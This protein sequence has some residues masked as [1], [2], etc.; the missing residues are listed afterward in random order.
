M[1]NSTTTE[2]NTMAGTFHTTKTAKIQFALPEFNDTAVIEH[3]AHVA[4]ELGRYDII[5]GGDLLKAIGMDIK[6]S[7]MM[8]SWGNTEVPMKSMDATPNVFTT[9]DS[10]PIH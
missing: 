2:W 4:K 7:T 9:N 3:K 10:K 6:Y 1:K 8:M 5:V